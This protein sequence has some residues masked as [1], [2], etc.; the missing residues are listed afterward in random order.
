MKAKPDRLLY[1]K[2]ATLDRLAS[3][4][5]IPNPLTPE[6]RAELKKEAIAR[7]KKAYRAKHK[8]KIYA[9]IKKERSIATV[10]R[11]IGRVP[12]WEFVQMLEDVDQAPP[13]KLK[14][15]QTYLRKNEDRFRL[16]RLQ[17]TRLL[18]RISARLRLCWKRALLA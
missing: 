3:V 5:G 2:P 1:L 8:K 15:M 9:A 11:S 14:Q 16:S 10:K 6:R 17:R 12:G 18:M 7:N 13:D 4:L